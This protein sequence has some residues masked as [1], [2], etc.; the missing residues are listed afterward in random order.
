MDAPRLR[1]RVGRATLTMV[2]STTTR[3]TERHRTAST[4]QRR[5]LDGEAAESVPPVAVGVTSA[6]SIEGPGTVYGSFWIGGS[7]DTLVVEHCATVIARCSSVRYR[8]DGKPPDQDSQCRDGGGAPS[9][10]HRHPGNGGPR[11]PLGA[12]DRR[13]RP[14]RPDGRLQPLRVQVRDRRGALHP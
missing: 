2:L 14:R 7:Q 10:G 11:R 12:P 5:S 13:G 9:L 8:Y 3:K 6:S 1:L 4:I